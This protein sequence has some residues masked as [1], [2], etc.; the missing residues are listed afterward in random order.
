MPIF[1]EKC[2]PWSSGPGVNKILFFSVSKNSDGDNMMVMELME[3]SLQSYLETSR[4]IKQGRI[5]IAL[6]V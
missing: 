2:P 5:K 4:L 3:G 6:L 1:I